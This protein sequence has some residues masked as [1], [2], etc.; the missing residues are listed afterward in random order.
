M[1][2]KNREKRKQKI[3][4]SFAQGY[5]NGIEVFKY[6]LACEVEKSKI[7]TS[8]EINNAINRTQNML[9]NDIK[10][11]IGLEINFIRE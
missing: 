1:N 10:D 9:A 8:T 6:Y 11:K 7:L 3:W 2:K 5:I 4:K